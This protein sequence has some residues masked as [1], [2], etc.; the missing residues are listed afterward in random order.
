M[1]SAVATANLVPSEVRDRD[2]VDLFVLSARHSKVMTSLPERVSQVR[3][4]L[5][6]ETATRVPSAEKTASWIGRSLPSSFSGDFP[7][8]FP[9]LERRENIFPSQ[10]SLAFTQESERECHEFPAGLAGK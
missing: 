4:S 1:W 8:G 9:D 5:S 7:V 3:T 10:N 6:N 2:R